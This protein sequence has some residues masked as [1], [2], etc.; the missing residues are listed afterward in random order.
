M[1]ARSVTLYLNMVRLWV[2]TCLKDTQAIPN[3]TNK[4]LK[5]EKNENSKGTYFLK[6]KASTLNSTVKK[7]RSTVSKFDVSG[8]RLEKST[9]RRNIL[10]YEYFVNHI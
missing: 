9:K 1:F 7:N 10:V 2:V 5:E 8:R 4:S 6:L 3:N